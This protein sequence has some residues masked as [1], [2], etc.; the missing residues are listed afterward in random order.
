MPGDQR[1]GE[2]LD[3]VE[4]V[5]RLQ[6]HHFRLGE[7]LP[8]DFDRLSERPGHHVQLRDGPGDTISRLSS[9]T[10]GSTTLES[11]QYLGYGTVVT[12]AHPRPAPRFSVGD[13]LAANTSSTCIQKKA[14]SAR[15]RCCHIRIKSADATPARPSVGLARNRQISLWN[16]RPTARTVPFDPCVGANRSPS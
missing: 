11:Y 13:A 16:G 9:I 4:G 5:V 14:S 3:D 10:D 6:L 8:A 1:L 7:H 2:R 12:R 15:G